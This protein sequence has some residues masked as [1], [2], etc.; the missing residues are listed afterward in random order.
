MSCAEDASADGTRGPQGGEHGLFR[1]CLYFESGL[2]NLG[3]IV[4]II[5]RYGGHVETTKKNEG[6]WQVDAGDS[7]TMAVQFSS[8]PLMMPSRAGCG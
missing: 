3:R 2:L 8:I 5:V 6:A 7:T 4:D 1:T